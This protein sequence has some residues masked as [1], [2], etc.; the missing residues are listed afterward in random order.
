MTISS[1][2]CISV[3]QLLKKRTSYETVLD[4]KHTSTVELDGR[5]KGNLL[6][7]IVALEGGSELLLSSVE[8]VDIS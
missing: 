5:L 7:D 6:V 2:F 1:F 8:T 4:I 3:L